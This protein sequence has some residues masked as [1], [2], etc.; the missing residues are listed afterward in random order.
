MPVTTS[1]TFPQKMRANRLL[2]FAWG[3]LFLGLLLTIV[4]SHRIKDEIDS[5]E[6]HAF[7]LRCKE[8][9][10]KIEIRLEKQKQM[11]RSSAA[12]FDASE[13]VTREEWRIY[14]NRLSLN[15]N[16][17]GIQA[18]GFSLWIKP[19][20]LKAHEKNIRQEGFSDYHVKPEGQREAYT[21]IV[22]IEPFEGR[23]LRAF[24]YDMYSEPVRHAAMSKAID[25]NNVTLS[26]KVILL[27]EDDL[28]RAQ[29]GT[30]MYAPIYQK[31]K[32]IETVEQRRESIFGWVYS[33]FRMSDLLQNVVLDANNTNLTNLN[34]FVYDG[35]QKQ[36]ENLLY[37]SQSEALPS[38]TQPF[39]TSETTLT[40]FGTEWLLH[41][42]E[43]NPVQTPFLTYL[44]VGIAILA[45][46]FISVL[47]FFLLYSQFL[48]QKQARKLAAE[49]TR[50]LREKEKKLA[51]SNADLLQF[52]TISAHH[53]QE[54]SRRLVS[55]VQ[56]L[57]DELA[58]TITLDQDVAIVLHFIEQSALR[59]RALVRDIQLYL[60]STT[61]RAEI[62]SVP[63][64]EVLEKAIEH[65][66]PLIQKTQAQIHFET[67][68]SVMIDRPRLYDIFNV[69]LENA[70]RYRKPE[71]VPVIHIHGEKKKDR[72]YY[73]VTD[74]GVGI[75]AQYRER[76]FLVFERL[77]VIENQNSTGIG[78][79]IVRRIVESCNGSASLSETVGGG[80]TVIFDLPAGN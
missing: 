14:V 44:N 61:P 17:G 27:Q 42:E 40:F 10:A 57:Q 22:Y 74:N 63:V 33:P 28:T 24:G 72:V 8:I 12:M 20:Q 23:N 26:G 38:N 3:I 53:L 60:A 55:F 76:V 51:A 65:N 49:L 69:L 34:L 21:S 11:L 45:G 18:L 77:Q 50:R 4:V 71:S 70:L 75:P 25:T 1:Q 41:F 2:L 6:R 62:E 19:E 73:Y 36:A 29:A 39:F 79:A 16:L 52:S 30:L 67:L 35:N 15:R 78:L 80:I 37:Q 32:P 58:K 5:F 56:R 59:Q 54:P 68:P 46:T 13:K 9:T 64:V 31:N 47:L 7:E 48:I 66:S 43:F